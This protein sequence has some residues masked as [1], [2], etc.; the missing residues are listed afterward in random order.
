MKEGGRK[1]RGREGCKGGRG[2]ETPGKLGSSWVPP[3]CPPHAAGCGASH[4]Y[5]DFS[6]FPFVMVGDTQNWEEQVR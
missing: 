6:V 3:P 4:Q 2:Q 1:K 5:L